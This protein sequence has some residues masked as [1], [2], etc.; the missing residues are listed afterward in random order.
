MFNSRSVKKSKVLSSLFRHKRKLCDVERN[1]ENGSKH[2]KNK[3]GSVESRVSEDSG[4]DDFRTRLC[5]PLQETKKLIEIKQRPSKEV[6]KRKKSKVKDVAD[7]FKHNSGYHLKF[8]KISPANNEQI[9]SENTQKFLLPCKTKEATST[10]LFVNRNHGIRNNTCITIG[11]ECKKTHEVSSASDFLDEREH[12]DLKRKGMLLLSRSPYMNKRKKKRVDYNTPVDIQQEPLPSLISYSSRSSSEEHEYNVKQTISIP[13]GNKFQMN[14]QKNKVSLPGNINV[15]SIEK[16]VDTS[17]DR[18]SF[19]TEKVSTIKS[20]GMDEVNIDYSSDN[21]YVAATPPP[22]DEI[23]VIREH[24]DCYL[25]SSETDDNNFTPRQRELASESSE[26]ESAVEGHMSDLVQQNQLSSLQSIDGIITPEPLFDAYS[27]DYSEL[28]ANK[29]LIETKE[30]DLSN[31]KYVSSTFSSISRS[32]VSRSAASSENKHESYKETW[33]SDCEKKT[34]MISDDDYTFG[35]PIDPRTKIFH[36]NNEA[37]HHET[38][39][40]LMKPFHENKIKTHKWTSKS[41][42]FPLSRQKASYHPRV[43]NYFPHQIGNQ[44]LLLIP[45]TQINDFTYQCD[46]NPYLEILHDN[47]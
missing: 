31:I 30:N 11:D 46:T 3:N 4:E 23:R 20:T 8:S 28:V 39:G 1:R 24:S 27:F 34:I 35:N 33:I 9:L 6:R 32:S 15:S 17:N 44:Y 7:D 10:H 42:D 14:Y 25:I 22:L 43:F 12:G 5:A 38:N 37:S 16:N 45:W 40:N 47:K 18:I 21:S 41:D 29:A 26:D 36:S 2:S 13:S 19:L